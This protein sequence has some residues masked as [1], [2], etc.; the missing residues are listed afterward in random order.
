MLRPAHGVDRATGEAV[1][2][3]LMHM[4][5]TVGDAPPMLDLDGGPDGAVSRDGLVQG[6]YLHGL[7][8]AD[9]F[10]HAFLDR[11]RRRAPSGVAWEATVDDTLDRLA[12]H[13]EAHLAIDRML[14]AAHAGPQDRQ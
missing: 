6:C 10:R 4:G 11:L 14:D 7:F 8:A 9:G 5:E 1:R 13:L 2:G 12:D 3:Y